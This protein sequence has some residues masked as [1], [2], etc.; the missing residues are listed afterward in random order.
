[1]ILRRMLFVTL[2]LFSSAA[3]QAG[4]GEVA[5]VIDG[6][7]IKISPPYEE[8]PECK[9]RPG[10][11]AGVVKDFI[12]DSAESK[13]YP[14]LKGP[15]KRKVAVYI[16]K[17]YVAGSEAPFIVAQ[18][19]MG[20]RGLLPRVLDNLIA[21]KKI[22]AL[23]AVMIDSGG[24]DGPGSQ[25]GLEY[26]TVSDTYVNFI[27]TEVLPRI[28]REQNVKFTRDPEGRAAM[29]SSS[30]GAA[31]FTMGW[32]RPDLYRRILTYSGTY[33]NQQ[34]PKNPA[35]PH[36]AWEYHENLIPKN[37][38]K[39]LRVWLEVG[40][41]DNGFNRDEKSL[42]NWTRSNQRMATALKAK[43]YAY[44]FVFAEG[45]GHSDGKVLRATLPDALVW[46]W[47]GYGQK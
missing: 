45:A 39:P 32:F 42:H 41:K 17:Q 28:I 36:G 11:P 25:R 14:G 16:P 18:D 22:P 30:G 43:G 31:A 47:Q 5:P 38:A 26:D 12:M 1:M 40:E 24:G 29:G 44:K 46:L 27:E 15:Y 13:I 35:L 33:V 37:D 3:L 19:G 7:D 8:A 4:Q 9:V 2:L 10:V 6:G 20:Y 21:D 23:I 34:S